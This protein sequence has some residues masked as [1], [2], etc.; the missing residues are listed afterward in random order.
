MQYLLF[1]ALR[2]KTQIPHRNCKN[3]K[4]LPGGKRVREHKV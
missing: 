3:L 2:L 1:W 4:D